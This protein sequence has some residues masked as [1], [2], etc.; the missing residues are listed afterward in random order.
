MPYR[1]NTQKYGKLAIMKNKERLTKEMWLEKAL[2]VLKTQGSAKLHIASLSKDLG[3]S[4][5]SFYWH[6]KDRSDF[7]HAL[8]RF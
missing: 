7:I 8:V 6:F 3:V 5:G 2:E 1:V 4:K